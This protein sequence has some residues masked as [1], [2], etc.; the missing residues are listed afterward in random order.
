MKKTFRFGALLLSILLTFGC[1]PLAATEFEDA[2]FALC[3]A[4]QRNEIQT[5]LSNDYVLQRTV[6][7]V[8]AN[9][10]KFAQES[11]I[12]ELYSGAE[13]MYK[14]KDAGVNSRYMDLKYML[15]FSPKISVLEVKLTPDR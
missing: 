3:T 10:P 15:S 11:K 12:Q 5:I 4:I 13:V 1:I 6:A 7:L 9:Q 8:R 14:S 2:V